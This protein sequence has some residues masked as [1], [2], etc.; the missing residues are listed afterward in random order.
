MSLSTWLLP[1][2]F[3]STALFSQTVGDLNGLVAAAGHYASHGM[4]GTRDAQALAIHKITGTNGG[5]GDILMSRSVDVSHWQF[6][7]HIN[8]PVAAEGVDE[9]VLPKPH[10][11][12]L[13]ECDKG[14]FG[15][16]KYSPSMVTGVKSLEF[17]WIAI[18]LDT[19]I[20]QLNNLGYVRGFSSVA[21]ERPANPQFPD[22]YVY[23]FKC[24]WERTLVAISTQTGAFTWSQGY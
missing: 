20:A 3:V 22:E 4:G 14:I 1:A 12:V 13:V 17:T 15:S 19:A 10:R 21:L 5:K 23:L 9:G 6:L 2:V 18:S 24:P 7:Y 16:F 11:S 8:Q